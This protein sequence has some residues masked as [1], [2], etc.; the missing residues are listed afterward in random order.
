M[1]TAPTFGLIGAAGYI[2]PR[3]L[4]AI[5]TV[6]GK[7][8][9]ACDLHDSVGVLDSYFPKAE[10]SQSPPAFFNAC[11]AA[12]VDYVVVCTPNHRHVDHV[13]AAFGAGADVICEKPLAL[14]RPETAALAAME[15]ATGRRVYTVLQLREL[16]QVRALRERIHASAPQRHD[17]RVAYVSRRGA[18]YFTSWKGDETRSGG[19]AANIG[20]HLFDLLTWLFGAPIEVEVHE[21]SLA[22][23][24]GRVL[25]VE[26][27]VNFLLSVD[28]TDLPSGAGH[29]HRVLS[30]DGRAL[31]LTRD[32]AWDEGVGQHI[33]EPDVAFTNAHVAVYRGVLAG[34]GWT[35]ED[36]QPGIDLT[37]LI[38][39]AS[40]THQSGLTA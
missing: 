23:V 1:P 25:L 11:A 28:P 14:S 15:R 29:A 31:D 19:V 38:R 18:W 9:F 40:C 35:I 8:L 36:V 39:T 7:L 34:D 16:S 6:G 10:F 4:A 12:G 33:P 22:R 3:H 24:R 20:A 5:A 27:E 30:V 2:A 21:R 37:Y 26:A 13:L 17:V 32:A